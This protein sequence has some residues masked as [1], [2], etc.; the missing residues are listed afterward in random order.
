M[1]GSTM[2]YNWFAKD[3]DLRM[4]LFPPNTESLVPFDVSHWT[5]ANFIDI[6]NF[7]CNARRGWVGIPLQ[8]RHEYNVHGKQLPGPKLKVKMNLISSR[9]W[10]TCNVFN[11]LARALRDEH[12]GLLADFIPFHIRCSPILLLVSWHAKIKTLVE[13]RATSST[14]PG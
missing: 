3:H 9:A 10:C 8:L 12:Y 11:R 5:W 6:W 14:E 13:S 4:P 7:A 1:A 2:P